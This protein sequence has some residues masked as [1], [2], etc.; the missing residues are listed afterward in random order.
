MMV[1]ADAEIFVDVPEKARDDMV[2]L[3]PGEERTGDAP[4]SW[5]ERVDTETSHMD[6]RA[7]A[8]YPPHLIS[9]INVFDGV[10]SEN[11]LFELSDSEQLRLRLRLFRLN[12]VTSGLCSARFTLHDNSTNSREILDR[13]VATGVP[14]A[15]VKCIQSFQSGQVDFTFTRTDSRD[16]FL[17]K[18]AITI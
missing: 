8:V 4:L 11:R 7:Q 13:I 16:L 3:L 10:L 2:I 12:G 15:H 1:E 6:N 18:A 17:S 9:E 5:P 14:G